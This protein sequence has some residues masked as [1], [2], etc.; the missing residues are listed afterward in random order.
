M[1]YNDYGDEYP[2]DPPYVDYDM[3]STINPGMRM[4]HMSRDIRGA[5]PVELY[6]SA[7]FG[8]RTYPQAH[9]EAHKISTFAME[10]KIWE[11]DNRCQYIFWMVI[12][13]M[14]FMI[15]VVISSVLTLLVSVSI[16][17]KNA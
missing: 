5:R 4:Q 1:S 12:V 14:I 9:P 11:M 7:P 17:K 6:K 2:L 13:L 10:Q 15:V 8:A 3:A 16:S